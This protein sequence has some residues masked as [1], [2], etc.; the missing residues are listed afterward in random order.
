MSR[1]ADIVIIGAGMAGAATAHH[2]REMGRT[3]VLVLEREPTPGVHSS[4]RNAAII[5]ASHVSETEAPLIEKGA[6]ELRRGRLAR[7]E[8]NGVMLLGDGDEDVAAHFPH[9]RGSG[10]WCPQDGVV[11]VATLLRTYL[12]EV[13]VIYEAHLVA[14]HRRNG[15]HEL[16]TTAG[17]VTCRILVNAAGP[18]AGEL[19]NLPLTPLNRHLFVTTPLE[20]VRPDWPTVWDGA[21]GLYF[22]PESGGL[23]L[24]ACDEISSEPGQYD[25]DLRVLESLADKLARTQP[26]LGEL[27]I[28]SQW[29]GQR[30]FAPDRSFVIGYD[31][32]EEGVFHVAGLGGHGVTASYAIGRMAARLLTGQ[33][34]PGSERFSPA[35]LLE[36]AAAPHDG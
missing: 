30:T 10:L 12:A 4:G 21:E 8:Q 13:E 33:Q 36:N 16:D 7:F 15:F 31:P 1:E 23:L 17:P 11:D 34:A 24:S 18:W 2:L 20:W 25:Q 3:D 29:V 28:L 32:R 22:R 5:R 6:A 14:R 35:R 19:G 9:A 27:S 26:D